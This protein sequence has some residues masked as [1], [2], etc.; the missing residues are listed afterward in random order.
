MTPMK[1]VRIHDYGGLEA[2]RYEDAPI[3][4]P[5]QGEALVRVRAAGV[6]PIDWKTRTGY[7]KDTNWHH[8][9]LTLGWDFAGVVQEIGPDTSKL[10]PGDAVYAFMPLARPGGYA[11]YTLVTEA[12][13]APKPETLDFETSAA[14][15]L[16][17]LT[18]WQG[19]FEIADL[20]EGQTILIHAAAGGVGHFAVQLAKLKGARVL[21][22]ASERNRGYLETI[23]VDEVIDYQKIRFEDVAENVDVVLDGVGGDVQAR[24]WQVIKP[25]GILVSLTALAVPDDLHAQTVRFKRM[26]VHPDTAQLAYL[27]SLIDNGMLE[28]HVDGVLP[29]EDARRAHELIQ[30]GHTRGKIVLRT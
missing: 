30:T 27:A 4:D 5:G 10:N 6:N 19:L 22:T 2:M 28:P 21:G 9:P 15:P 12:E 8:L 13:A 26:L 11:Q 14:V 3:P 25:G 29:L 18:A 17:A 7:L 24:S 20:R 23:G 16:A 1:A